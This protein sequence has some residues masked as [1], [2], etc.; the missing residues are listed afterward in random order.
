MT[1]KDKFEDWAQM[2]G[3]RLE[4]QKNML[5]GDMGRYEFGPTQAA[6]EVWEDAWGEALKS[7]VVKLPD[8][9]REYHRLH[10]LKMDLQ[11]DTIQVLMIFTTVLTMQGLIMNN[12]KDKPKQLFNSEELHRIAGA[13]QNLSNCCY[14]EIG[15]LGLADDRHISQEDGALIP[16][17]KQLLN[18]LPLKLI[19]EVMSEQEKEKVSGK[20]SNKEE[21]DK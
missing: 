17:M 3:L 8:G 20:E 15:L 9:K 21:N 14:F 19:F 12:F 4:R 13:A 6:F 18:T 11:K 1:F 5:G 16:Y 10:I 7:V 2:Q